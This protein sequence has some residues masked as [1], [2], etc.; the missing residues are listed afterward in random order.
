MRSGWIIQV[1]PKSSDN[2]SYK[3][4]AWGDLRERR[5]G[6]VKMEVEPG[7]MWPQAKEQQGPP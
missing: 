2:C 4:K 1:D 5:E 7:V 3:R 6:P